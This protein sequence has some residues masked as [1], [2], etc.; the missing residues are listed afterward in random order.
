MGEFDKT[1]LQLGV[2][3]LATNKVDLQAFNLLGLLIK[4]LKTY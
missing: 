3:L 1:L 4:F 2:L